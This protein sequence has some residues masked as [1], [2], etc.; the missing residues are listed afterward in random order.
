MSPLR[1]ISRNQESALSR[2]GNVRRIRAAHNLDRLRIGRAGRSHERRPFGILRTIVKHTTASLEDRALLVRRARPFVRFQIPTEEFLC[3]VALI[4]RL[5]LS[6]V[7]SSGGS[8]VRHAD[9]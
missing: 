6:K 7:G 3:V 4:A 5:E 9:A 8:L 1:R 2:S